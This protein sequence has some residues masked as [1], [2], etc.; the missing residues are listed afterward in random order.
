MDWASP[1]SLG[2]PHQAGEGFSESPLS[3]GNQDF[4]SFDASFWSDSALAGVGMDLDMPSVATF[5]PAQDAD[6]D[7]GDGED[8]DEEDQLLSSGPPHTPGKRPLF[9]PLAPG[10]ADSRPPIVPL[11]YH[12]PLVEYQSTDDEAGSQPQIGGGAKW[13]EASPLNTPVKTRLRVNLKQT[14]HASPLI[15][16]TAARRRASSPV[17]HEDGGQDPG[18]GPSADGDAARAR[19]QVNSEAP[20]LPPHHMSMPPPP[21]PTRMVTGNAATRGNPTAR[22]KSGSTYKPRP[23]ALARPPPP[24]PAPTTAAAAPPAPVAA[25]MDGLPAPVVS[26]ATSTGAAPPPSVALVAVPAPDFSVAAAGPLA[27]VPAPGVSIVAATPDRAP[28]ASPPVP[29][30][31][32]VAATPEHAPTASPPAPIASIATSSTSSVARPPGITTYSG[33]RASGPMSTT[34]PC[35]VRTLGQIDEDGSPLVLSPSD[36]NLTPSAPPMDIMGFHGHYSDFCAAS[37][38]EEVP[39]PPPPPGHDMDEPGPDPT[40]ADAADAGANAHS[41]DD[42]DEGISLLKTGKLTV[43]Q[44]EALVE[45]VHCVMFSIKACS[46]ATGLTQDRVAR[47]FSH[48]MGDTLPPRT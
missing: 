43:F 21:V 19:V 38:F 11:S 25:A 31:S 45:C 12:S 5:P 23:S 37:G 2:H 8:E 27:S 48:E 14:E 16:N 10:T 20:P 15:K 36:L 9:D 24:A 47:A 28:T 6:V 7:D 18:P 30:V 40:N 17:D 35:Q 44:E 42:D 46:M 32:I 4:A 22:G 39:L 34:P 13:R 26:V 3:F 29:I 33:R 1:S 41:S